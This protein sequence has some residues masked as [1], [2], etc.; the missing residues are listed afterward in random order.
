MI[1][2]MQTLSHKFIID[3]VGIKQKLA[4][5]C[6]HHISSFYQIFKVLQNEIEML[7]NLILLFLIKFI[8]YAYKNHLEINMLVDPVHPTLPMTN[9]S[10]I[11]MNISIGKPLLRCRV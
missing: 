8:E 10:F 11:P 2:K 9:N 6:A 1:N 3:F 7:T 5:L 4:V